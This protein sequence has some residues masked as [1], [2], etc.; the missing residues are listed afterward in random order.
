MGG[1]CSVPDGANDYDK[2]STA[3]KP[4]L[5]VAAACTAATLAICVSLIV[6]HLRRYRCPKE[7]RQ[8]VRIAFSPVVFAVV[9]LFE[10][11]NYEIAQYID[12]IGDVYEAFCLCALLLLV[13]PSVLS[14]R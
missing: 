7:Q 11:Y 13:S 6:T 3:H 2:K 5:F 10:V 1:S 12:P 8:I 14:S 9:A 4:M